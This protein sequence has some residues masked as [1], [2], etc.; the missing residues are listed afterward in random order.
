M[1][2]LF[3]RVVDELVMMSEDDRELADGIRWL[4]ARARQRGVSFY[5]EVSEVLGGRPACA[6]S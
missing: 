4:D 2:S 6:R 1:E 5:D 3:S